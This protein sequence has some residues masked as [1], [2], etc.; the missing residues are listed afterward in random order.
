MTP[1][2]VYLRFPRT[3]LVYPPFGAS[4]LDAAIGAQIQ[5]DYGCRAGVCG[6]CKALL[7]EGEIE[8]ENDFALSAEEKAVGMILTC[9][10][11]ALGPVAIDC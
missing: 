7:I 10:A 9:Q 2:K 4:L 11:R 6:R 5:I 1:L 8:L 3:S